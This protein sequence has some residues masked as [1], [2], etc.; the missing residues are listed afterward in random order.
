MK[1]TEVLR[2][3]GGILKELSDQYEY[4]KNEKEDL[5]DLEI[6]LFTA[7]ANFL[8][9][10]IEILRKLNFQNRSIQKIAEKPEV[11]IT[12]DNSKEKFFEPVVQQIKPAFVP[13]AKILPEP[14][15]PAENEVPINLTEDI[16]TPEINLEPEDSGDSYSYTRQDE[17]ETIRHELVLDENLNW[18]EDDEE[19]P[20]AEAVE[21]P[22]E[23]EV[24]TFAEPEVVEPKVAPVVEEDKKEEIAPIIRTEEIKPPIIVEEVK[25]Q[26]K[27]EEVKP[28]VIEPEPVKKVEAPAH[29]I[30]TFNQ[31][32]SSQL[33][34]K[35]AAEQTAIKPI[36]DI[37]L[38]ITLNDKLL[39]VKDLFNGY[40]LAYS[41]AV[42]ILNRFNTFDEATRFLNVNYVTK[43]NW[44]SKP[45]T[46]EKFYA[47][48]KRRYA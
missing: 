41:E 47:L 26:E 15:K 10:H 40:S 19:L 1:Q 31:K 44:E 34:D 45:E 46:T 14:A 33:A 27:I 13:E 22:A 21:E 4:L 11:I 7:N 42:D 24:I 3:I 5:N 38:A 37:K 8:T 29:E 6:E 17:P 28:V 30:L 12:P 16:F 20:V 43:N 32:I 48:L 18:D 35:A 9:D 2:K 36:S 25:P 39:F 23:E